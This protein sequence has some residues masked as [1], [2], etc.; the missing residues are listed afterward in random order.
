MSG[1]PLR[2]AMKGCTA[3]LPIGRGTI[4]KSLTADASAPSAT[5]PSLRVTRKVPSVSHLCVG[6]TWA[7]ES[8]SPKYQ[9]S[10]VGE[11][12]TADVKDTVSPTW[13][14]QRS[15]L[16]SLVHDGLL[17]LAA[18]AGSGGGGG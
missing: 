2:C 12:S 16:P 7:E 6:F 13:A 10:E 8:P 1:A 17:N 3:A 11:P 15:P 9:P 4:S 5:R 14:R 18:S